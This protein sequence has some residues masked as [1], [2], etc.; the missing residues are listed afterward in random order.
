MKN[1]ILESKRATWRSLTMAFLPLVSQLDA[2]QQSAARSAFI[3][4]DLDNQVRLG[5]SPDTWAVIRKLRSNQKALA[6][7]EALQLEMEAAKARRAEM[8]ARLV[9]AQAAAKA[10]GQSL[11]DL[12]SAPLEGDHFSTVAAEWYSGIQAGPRTGLLHILIYCL[13]CMMIMMGGMGCLK[14]S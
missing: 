1:P 4:G 13:I 3:A 11:S 14:K 6:S 8:E 9:E 7:R 5:T 12:D 10:S 2:A